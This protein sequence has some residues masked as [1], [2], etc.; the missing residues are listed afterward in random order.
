MELIYKEI[1]QKKIIERESE[2]CKNYMKGL[3]PQLDELIY[4]I[5]EPKF[6]NMVHLLKEGKREEIPINLQSIIPNNQT[7][8]FSRK[9]NINS[10]NNLNLD[11]VAKNKIQIDIED[12]HENLQP[13]KESEE[14]NNCMS[15]KINESLDYSCITNIQ[16]SLL[17]MS[18]TCRK[19]FHS[20]IFNNQNNNLKL[21][22]DIGKNNN[23]IVESDNVSDN[24]DTTSKKDKIS[25]S[26]I[27]EKKEKLSKSSQQPQT[28]TSNEK[29]VRKKKKFIMVYNGDRMKRENLIPCTSRNI[30]VN[31]PLR[32]KINFKAACDENTKRR[33]EIL[34]QNCFSEFFLKVEPNYIMVCGTPKNFS[35]LITKLR[36]DI[37]RFKLFVTIFLH[38][39]IGTLID[40]LTKD[41][42]TNF[43][44]ERIQELMKIY[45]NKNNLKWFYFNSQKLNVIDLSENSSTQSAEV[46]LNQE[47][48]DLMDVDD[49]TVTDE[50]E[51][52]VDVNSSQNEQ[53]RFIRKSQ[54]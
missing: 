54:N 49:E 50:T 38:D 31:N 16:N 51:N 15:V 25:K 48:N 42:T 21:N 35:N 53:R 43:T 52:R 20:L 12:L 13:E 34:V 1:N 37:Y 14:D 30:L 2:E 3:K 33:Q 6:R 47:E 17:T 7:K 23:M 29:L 4:L 40:Y 39:E 28:K 18:T 10:N 8:T 11:H 41:C 46:R 24:T 44:E 9:S 5:N 19:K 45:P 32:M 26:T 22:E 36:T 27:T